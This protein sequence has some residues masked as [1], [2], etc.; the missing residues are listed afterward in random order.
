MSVQA[1]DYGKA[2]GAAEERQR[3]RDWVLAN[4]RVF[5]LD[6]GAVF[7]RDSFNSEDLLAFI[8]SGEK[9]GETDDGA[10]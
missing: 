9:T 10:S 4:R 3:I 8:D 6:D 2:D 5:E 1:Y 7:Y